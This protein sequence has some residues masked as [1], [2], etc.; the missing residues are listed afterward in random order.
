LPRVEGERL[1][2]TPPIEQAAI[3]DWWSLVGP[4]DLLVHSAGNRAPLTQSI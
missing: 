3:T 4:L 1:E 2:M